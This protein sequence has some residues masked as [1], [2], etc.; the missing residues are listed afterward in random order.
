MDQSLLAY[1]LCRR[2]L[3]HSDV[4]TAKVADETTHKVEPKYFEVRFQTN[5]IEHSATA[6]R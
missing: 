1:R 5:S 4:R 2:R 3:F 6:E